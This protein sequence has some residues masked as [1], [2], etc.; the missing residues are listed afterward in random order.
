MTAN[1]LINEPVSVHRSVCGESSVKSL[2]WSLSAT[3]AYEPPR[4]KLTKF[5]QWFSAKRP[6]LHVELKNRRISFVSIRSSGASFVSDFFV[7]AANFADPSEYS[8][9]TART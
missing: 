7:A 3:Y 1:T 8:N 6:G 2:K 4:T 9:V 5:L